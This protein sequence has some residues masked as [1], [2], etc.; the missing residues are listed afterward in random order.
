MGIS[1]ISIL[2]LRWCRNSK[3]AVNDGAPPNSRSA[4]ATAVLFG[5]GNGY[6]LLLRRRLFGNESEDGSDRVR[7]ELFEMLRFDVTICQRYEL[8]A[9]T[10]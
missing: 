5:S 1:D 7:D 4:P 10:L 9:S 6:V 8:Y 2:Y 3:D